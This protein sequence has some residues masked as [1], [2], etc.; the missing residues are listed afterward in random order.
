MTNPTILPDGSA[1]SVLTLPLPNDHW[2]YT[3]REYREGEY[4]PIELPKPLL[5]HEQR[6]Q[7]VAAV[8]YAVR[9]AT[10]CGKE[11]DFDPDALVQN[12]VYALCGP[13]GAAIKAKGAIL[14]SLDAQPVA[15]VSV[16]GSYHGK[17]ILGCVLSSDSM[18]VGDKL[19]AAPVA[20][21]PPSQPVDPVHVINTAIDVM[22]RRDATIA[23][24]LFDFMGWLT[25]RKERLCL[26][27]ADDASPAV[28]AITEFAKMRNLS[29]DNAMVTDWQSVA[30]QANKPLSDAWQ[31]GY[32]A[33]V[34]DERISESNIGIA[35]YGAKV[36]PA[37]QNPY[38]IK[39]RG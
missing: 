12:A 36:N 33:G 39:E 29:L 11:I 2:L 10:M 19:Y 21:Q 24:V 16:M 3:P 26:S 17:P 32:K 13:Y 4:E 22:M 23:G 28:T 35:G 18:Q 38:G 14:R 7:V 34:E 6:D 15:E 25:T 37:R 20:A 31:E 9:G 5:T 30:A 8:R 27:S 1:F